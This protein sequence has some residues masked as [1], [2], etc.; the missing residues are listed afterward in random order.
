MVL[1]L[2][3]NFVVC[4]CKYVR[5]NKEWVRASCRLLVY[6]ISFVW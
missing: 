3:I 4:R 6:G 2:F 1:L 5:E